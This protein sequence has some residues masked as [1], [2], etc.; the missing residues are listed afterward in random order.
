MA[1]A[2]AGVTEAAI[3]QVLSVRNLEMPERGGQG[4]DA[5]KA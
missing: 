3:R 1:Q 2:R 5:S 4:G